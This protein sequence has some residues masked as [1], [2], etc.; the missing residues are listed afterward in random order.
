M[1]IHAAVAA[2]A[3]AGLASCAP[4]ARNFTEEEL[5][6]VSSYQEIM[7]YL[8]TQADPAFD[9]AKGADPASVPP[10]KVAWLGETGRKLC[11]AA[12]RLAEPAFSKGAGYDKAAAAFAEKAKALELAAATKDGAKALQATR[13]V[14]GACAA[15]HAAFR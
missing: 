11:V 7:W 4:P 9:Y 8:A 6:K 2:L 12:T 14:K 5:K 3:V 13:D 15:C 10:E 1:R